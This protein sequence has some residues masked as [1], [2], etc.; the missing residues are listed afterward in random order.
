MRGK[1][2]DCRYLKETPGSQRADVTEEQRIA[3][4]G[5][6]LSAARPR[7]VNST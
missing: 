1:Q 3:C 5:K 7:T 4:Y 6:T 2:R